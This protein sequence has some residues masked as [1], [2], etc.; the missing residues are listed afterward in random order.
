M[1]L[2]QEIKNLPTFSIENKSTRLIMARIVFAR[3]KMFLIGLLIVSLVLIIGGVLFLTFDS[4][5]GFLKSLT[6][7]RTNLVFDLI[8]IGI[9]LLSYSSFQIVRLRYASDFNRAISI[10]SNMT[11]SKIKQND[12]SFSSIIG[13]IGY[14]ALGLIILFQVGGLFFG[15]I[16]LAAS[17]VIGVYT[18]RVKP[19]DRAVL[20]QDSVG[21]P[22]SLPSRKEES[23]T[24]P[25]QK[26]Q[27]NQ[28]ASEIKKAPAKSKLSTSG[29]KGNSNDQSTNKSDSNSSQSI[30]DLIKSQLSHPSIQSEGAGKKKDLEIDPK[31]NAPSITT[32]TV[33]PLLFK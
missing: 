5:I 17:G 25:N 8:L 2:E 24:E 31:I 27:P 32:P 11:L 16:G 10:Y 26:D 19:V 12:F 6:L 30:P 21:Q 7:P 15:G 14:A 28:S 23:S 9:I 33:S 22:A 29:F 18:P 13:N 3:W 4:S 20:N 1:N